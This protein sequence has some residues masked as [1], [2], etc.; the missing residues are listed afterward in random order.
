MPEDTMPKAFANA[1]S[2]AKTDDPAATQAKFPE[3]F[4]H[5]EN[6]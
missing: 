6:L 1:A 5:F 2:Q 4:S 3:L